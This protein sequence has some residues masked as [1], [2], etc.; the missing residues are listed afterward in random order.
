MKMLGKSTR[1]RWTHTVVHSRIIDS[2]PVLLRAGLLTTCS[3]CHV[4]SGSRS[5]TMYC[6]KNRNHIWRSSPV[7]KSCS[8]NVIL[9]IAMPSIN[10]SVNNS[11]LRSYIHVA[12]FPFLDHPCFC[13]NATVEVKVPAWSKTLVSLAIC[14]LYSHELTLCNIILLSDIYVVQTRINHVQQC[15]IPYRVQNLEFISRINKCWF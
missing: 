8:F 10:K 3:S 12:I 5:F 4:C 11:V 6:W 15:H 9:C 7:Y 13:K 2:C 1:D 14:H